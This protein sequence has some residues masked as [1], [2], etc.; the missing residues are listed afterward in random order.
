MQVVKIVKAG[1]S[2]GDMAKF[3]DVTTRSMLSWLAAFASEGRN[4]L[5]ARFGSGRP[6]KVT[7][8][9][10]QWIAIVARNNTPN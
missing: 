5:A 2:V 8:Q 9:Q 4:G 3:F 6:P 7:H 10:M 1:A